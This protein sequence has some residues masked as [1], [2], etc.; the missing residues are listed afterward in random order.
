[1]SSLTNE[2]SPESS[3]SSGRSVLLHTKIQE[4]PWISLDELALGL[5]WLLC[6]NDKA[7]HQVTLTKRKS[8]P[9][10]VKDPSAFE[11]STDF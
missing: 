10:V 5:P 11:A 1:M 4:P 6:Q 2:E 8:K 3:S 9:E 7:P